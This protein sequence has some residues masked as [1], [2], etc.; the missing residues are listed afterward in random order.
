MKTGT[1]KEFMDKA[2]PLGQC[3]SSALAPIA[4]Q[5]PLQGHT[6]SY[7]RLCPVNT[8]SHNVPCPAPAALFSA[9]AGVFRLRKTW[10]EVQVNID[11]LIDSWTK[12]GDTDSLRL[13]FGDSTR[14]YTRVNS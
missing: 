11:L 9:Q 14:N 12:S 8:V 4:P 2:G 5:P 7:A 6:E 10:K 3:V 13:T 1:I